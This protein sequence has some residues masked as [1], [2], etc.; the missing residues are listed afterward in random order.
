MHRAPLGDREQPF[1]LAVVEVPPDQGD[2]PI[3]VADPPFLVSH[4]A[5]SSA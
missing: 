2:G 5:Q 1:A 4:S 3:D